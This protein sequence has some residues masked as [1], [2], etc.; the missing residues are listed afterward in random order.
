MYLNMLLIAHCLSFLLPKWCGGDEFEGCV[1]FDE[2]HRA[3]N[4]VAKTK[5]S[6][7]GKAVFDLQEALPNARIV[8]CSATGQK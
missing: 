4:L 2:C 1:L 6:K 3:K 5:S 7:C 8:Y